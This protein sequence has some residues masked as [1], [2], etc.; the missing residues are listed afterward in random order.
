MLARVQSSLLQGIDALPC[1]IEVDFTARRSEDETPFA[2]IV[3]LPDAAVKESLERVRSAMVNSGYF[4]P[5]GRT[6]INLAPADVRKEGPVYDLPIAIGALLVQGIG[7][8]V[9]AA[10]STKPGKEGSRGATAT[11]EAPGIDHRRYLFAGELALDGRLRP[12]KGAIALAA[13]A[14]AK[15]YEGVVIPYDNAAEAAVVEGIAVLGARSLAEVVGLMTGHL[16]AR[17]FPSPDVAQLLK[18]ATAPIDFGEIKGQETVKRAIVVAA[19]GGHNLVMLGP[20]GTGKTMMAKALPGVL[21]PLTPDEAIQV[22]RIYSA[23]GQLTPGQGLISTRPVRTPHHTASG[24][25]IVGGGMIPRPGEIS[26]AHHGVLFLDELPEF[27]RDVLETLRQPM[28]DHVVT[29]ARSHSAVRFPANFMLVAAMNPTPRGDVAPG[30]VGRMEMERYL[31]KLSGPLLD[32]IDIHIEAPAVP[33][34]ELSRRNE[35]ATGTTT[36]QMREQMAKARARQ[37]ARQGE[38]PNARLSGKKLDEMVNLDEN[39]L[40]MLGQAMNEMGLSARAFDK[41]R[42][43]ART[44]ADLAESDVVTSEHI[45][46]AVQYRLLDRKV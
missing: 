34:R 24:A 43:I 27:P 23:A 2:G 20:A 16:E 31:A 28:E 10:K 29:I 19:A 13:L 36:A 14:K 11:E 17:P 22:T 32:R 46:E 18:Q 1:E 40:T 25:A 26:L 41:I 35:Q 42:R 9:R 44:I 6:I 39:A 8:P 3:G 38:I 30:E 37:H 33:F 5:D 7:A 21:P 12:I 4:F 15:G 45:G